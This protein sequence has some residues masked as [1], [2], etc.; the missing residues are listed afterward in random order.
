MGDEARARVL[1][2]SADDINPP[3]EAQTTQD[4]WIASAARGNAELNSLLASATS[5]QRESV[6][7]ALQGT[8]P[9]VSEVAAAIRRRDNAAREGQ[10]GQRPSPEAFPAGTPLPNDDMQ[11]TPPAPYG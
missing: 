7:N 8:L 9:T 1:Q 11:L 3:G 2:M 5:A 10:T 4:R 6:F